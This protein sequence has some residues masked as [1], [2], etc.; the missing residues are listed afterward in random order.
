MDHTL[1][2]VMV[3]SQEYLQDTPQGLEKKKKTSKN[4]GLVAA[5]CN[6]IAACAYSLKIYLQHCTYATVHGL[7]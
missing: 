3:D 2:I 6:G 1:K 7:M 5:Q 4:F